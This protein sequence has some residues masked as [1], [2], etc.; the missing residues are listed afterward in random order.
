MK[1]DRVEITKTNDPADGW[2]VTVFAKGS[3]YRCF[4]AASNEVGADPETGAPTETLVRRHWQ[5]N[6][7][8]FKRV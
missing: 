1:I 6:R 5:E 3:M 7:S 4:Y 8:T 2:T